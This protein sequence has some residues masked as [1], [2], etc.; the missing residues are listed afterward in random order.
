MNRLALRPATV[1]LYLALWLAPACTADEKDI[2]WQDRGD[3]SQLDFAAGP[4]G[5]DGSPQA[6][7]D[8]VKEDTS[9]SYPKVTVKD[10]RG[11]TWV[12]K[13]GR[14]VRSEPFASRI[15]WAAGYYVEPSYFVPQGVIQ[16]VHDLHRARTSIESNGAF[17]DARFQVRDPEYVYSAKHNWSWKNNPFRGTREMNGLKVILML[18]SNWDNK[19]ARDKDEGPNTGVF[20]HDGSYIYAFTDWGGTMGRWGN[21][22]Q[23]SVWEC[24]G[25]ADQTPLFLDSAGK[26]LIWGY[27]GRHTDFS[28]DVTRPD[29]EWIAGILAK[30]TDDQLRAGLKASGATPGEAECF[31][32]ELRRRVE[33]LQAVST[34]SNR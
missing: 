25:F 31:T 20:E 1:L 7:F 22:A 26:K 28:D 23:R 33:K 4:G 5:P 14:E 8:F 29:V 16:G 3:V 10:A 24:K 32:Q 12:V 34:S 17:K 11:R 19:D 27:R 21:V 9:G 2:L 18:T 13:F 15:A 6:P 30:I